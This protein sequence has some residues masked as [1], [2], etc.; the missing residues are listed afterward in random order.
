MFGGGAGNDSSRILN[1]EL[2][3]SA[4]EAVPSGMSQ[5]SNSAYYNRGSVQNLR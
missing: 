1:D 3:D 5:R 2:L 4:P